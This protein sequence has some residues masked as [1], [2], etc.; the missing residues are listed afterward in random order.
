MKNI[1]KT[2]L[3]FLFTVVYNNAIAQNPTGVGINTTSPKRALHVNG[4]LRIR[5]TEYKNTDTN[6]NKVIVTNNVGE[7]ESWDKQDIKN[8]MVSLAVETKKMYYSNS[9]SSNTT[10]TCGKFVISFSNNTEPQIKLL[11]APQ[12]GNP[13]SIYY[14]RT[15]KVNGNGNS[16]GTNNRTHRSNLIT[17]IDNTNTWQNI[18]VVTDL[19]VESGQTVNGRTY[20]LN[21]LDEYFLSYPGDKNLYRITFLARKMTTTT[22]SYTMICEKF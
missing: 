16:F 15:R 13:I 20:R 5:S 2:V 22:N 3:I 6:Y 1:K 7:I 18:S 12:V 11:T 8:K 9:P 14:S 21:T 4:D 10:V 17:T 19:A